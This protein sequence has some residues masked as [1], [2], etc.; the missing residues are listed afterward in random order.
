MRFAISIAVFLSCFSIVSA[1]SI[2]MDFFI[3]ELSVIPSLKE[4]ELMG[5]DSV[6]LDEV[7][8]YNL[9]KRPWIDI[10][11]DQIIYA[12]PLIRE[13][14]NEG[15]GEG[16]NLDLRLDN[17]S[18]SEAPEE[19]VEEENFDLAPMSMAFSTMR[20]T[21]ETSQRQQGA[22]AL[23]EGVLPKEVMRVL[24]GNSPCLQAS[25][26][27]E[28]YPN[29]YRNLRERDSI[30]DLISS[31][32][33]VELDHFMRGRSENYQ[34][35]MSIILCTD[36]FLGL[37]VVSRTQLAILR[38]VISN[39][40]NN[41]ENYDRF[42]KILSALS[43]EDSERISIIAMFLK[44]LQSY[45]GSMFLPDNLVFVVL[46][47]ASINDRARSLIAP[48]ADLNGASNN[49]R[50][51]FPLLFGALNQRNSELLGEHSEVLSNMMM[52]T[53]LTGNS[54][55]LENQVIPNNPFDASDAQVT[56]LMLEELLSD[57]SISESKASVLVDLLLNMPFL[58]SFL[59]ESINRANL[60]DDSVSISRTVDYLVS[61]YSDWVKIARDKKESEAIIKAIKERLN[62]HF[63]R[64]K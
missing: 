38:D 33:L 34:S 37:E 29:L 60:A 16:F 47:V 32:L 44:V 25:K 45:S 12:Y 30:S 43:L 31:Y 51:Q 23:E 52:H 56:M 10:A 17:E 9:F 19:V 35:I 2:P 46:S 13:N 64:R 6:F 50:D 4:S 3:D 11:H 36:F 22:T 41:F 15:E 20:T 27:E 53:L 61:R 26:I 57:Q 62:S 54:V 59:S 58:S 5:R 7:P 1:Y 21:I 24:E 49:W 40:F 8:Y 39:L 14:K 48:S 55:I 18:T 28:S 63:K 42:V